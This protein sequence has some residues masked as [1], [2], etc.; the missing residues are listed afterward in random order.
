MSFRVHYLVEDPE[1]FY[2]GPHGK[3]YRFA[4][5]GSRKFSYAD[6]AT[7]VA[8]FASCP[9][10]RQ[11]SVYRRE[12]RGYWKDPDTESGDPLVLVSG[13]KRAVS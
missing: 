13:H 1:G 12:C 7:S 3:R 5:D 9:D 2:E 4:C 11:T 10:C 6:R 8:S